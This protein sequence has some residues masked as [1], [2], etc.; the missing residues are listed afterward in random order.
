MCVCVNLPVLTR[1]TSC[2]YFWLGSHGRT[3]MG[4]YIIVEAF[5]EILG[6]RFL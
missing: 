4:R 3:S 1:T 6:G 5:S 2:F